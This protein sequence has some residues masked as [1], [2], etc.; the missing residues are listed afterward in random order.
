MACFAL[1]FLGG[2]GCFVLFFFFLGGGQNS[3]E[4]IVLL[5]NCKMG[6]L[7]IAP[8]RRMTS[9]ETSYCVPEV[10]PVKVCSSFSSR[11]YCIC[12]KLLGTSGNLT[13]TCVG[14]GGG[15]NVPPPACRDGALRDL[16]DEDFI[17]SD[18]G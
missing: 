17:L 15:V 1:F 4:A 8:P 11:P 9:T 2:G 3:H 10:K 7:G 12:A 5:V 13:A 6:V 14:L 18:G 16:D